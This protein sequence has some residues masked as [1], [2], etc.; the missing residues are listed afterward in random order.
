MMDIPLKSLNRPPVRGCQHLYSALRRTLGQLDRIGVASSSA[1]NVTAS[2]QWNPGSIKGKGY[3]IAILSVAVASGVTSLLQT[4]LRS[5]LSL[6]FVLAVVISALFGGLGPGLVSSI[7]SVSVITWHF[8]RPLYSSEVESVSDTIELVVF[9][10]VAVSINALNEARRRSEE[11]QRRVLQQRLDATEAEAHILRGLLP[12][13]AWC[14]RIQD[15]ERWL[16]IEAYARE[17]L[18]TE[19]SHGIC[20]D[21]LR[22]AESSEL[23]RR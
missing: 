14:K 21:C 1:S 10:V 22:K 9:G 23:T 7:L 13:C 12:M 11:V 2:F 15:E 16:P 5:T 18:N 19:F 6:P 3:L 20:P 8:T 17:H 4:Y